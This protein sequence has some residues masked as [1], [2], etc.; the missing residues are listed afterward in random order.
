MSEISDD[1]VNINHFFKF[2]LSLHDYGFI[3]RMLDDLVD[4]T[5][6]NCPRRGQQ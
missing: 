5:M 2:T 6:P 1:Y 3:N 4:F